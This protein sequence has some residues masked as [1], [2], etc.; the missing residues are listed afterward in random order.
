[1]LVGKF[2]TGLPVSLIRVRTSD[3]WAAA[4]VTGYLSGLVCISR[5]HPLI[6]MNFEEGVHIIF[7]NNKLVYS[8]FCSYAFISTYFNLINLRRIR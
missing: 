1:M 7:H 2:S 4:P 8:K 5:V 6:A 3:L